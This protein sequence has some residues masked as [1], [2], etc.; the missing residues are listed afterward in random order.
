MKICHFSSKI[1]S[2]ADEALDGSDRVDVA[3]HLEDC[4]LCQLELRQL[5]DLD[6]LFIAG[7]FEPPTQ[8]YWNE[9]PVRVI[10]RLNLLPEKNRL[11]IWW[12]DVLNAVTSISGWR[13]AAA[14]AFAMIFIILMLKKYEPWTNQS[15][16]IIAPG[17]V[18][19]NSELAAVTSP[20]VTPGTPETTDLPQAVAANVPSAKKTAPDNQF[21]EPETVAARGLKT[22]SAP[23]VKD[24][25]ITPLPSPKFLIP[26][27]E[28]YAA[29]GGNPAIRIF[30]KEASGWA[31]QDVDGF[32]AYPDLPQFKS[33]FAQT[34]WLVQSSSELDEKRNIWLSFI[35]REPDDT[36]YAMGV[37]N[38]AQV[39]FQISRETLEPERARTAIQFYDRNEAVLRPQLGDKKF[40]EYLNV[41][42][43]LKDN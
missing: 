33:D 1:S 15:T 26:E 23:L 5:R 25:F 2:F 21:P 41:L 17:I 11:G 43:S 24:D 35:S 31:F 29:Q 16:E 4:T 10:S 37:Y 13:M 3:R 38:L 30:S 22:I 19:N 7:L 6:T 40:E 34:L 39:L 9:V 28:M 18:D 20:A 36:Y 14:G 12:N 42:N 32:R 8:T 27:K